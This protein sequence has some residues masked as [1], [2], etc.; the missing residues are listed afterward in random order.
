MNDVRPRITLITPS[1]NQARFL[2]RTITSILNQNYPDLKYI[3]VDGGSTDGSVEIIRKY[4]T[5]LAW[6][7]SEKDNG[8][9][10]AINKGLKHATGEIIGWLNSDD[11]LAPGALQRIAQAYQAHP[12]IDLLYGHT[13]MI[14]EN[15]QVIR[16]L[17]AVPTNAYELIHFNPNIFS[18][19]GTTWR[20]R[21]HERIGYLDE[22]LHCTMDC[23]FWIRAAK[24]GVIH[25]I[26]IHLGNLRTYPQTKSY[27]LRKSF[28]EEQKLL[29]K[30]YGGEETSQFQKWFFA[31]RRSLRICASPKTLAYRFQM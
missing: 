22:S 27:L 16:R 2:E 29:D 7:V 18:Q 21:L 14:N 19:P 15:D 20:M 5:Q 4:E 17:C 24:A 30:R 23:D 9:A 10:H 6:W 31:V 25:F 8:Q 3:I 12:E 28:M 11:T 26:P 13:C 1:F